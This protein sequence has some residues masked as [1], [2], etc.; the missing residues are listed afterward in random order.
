MRALLQRVSQAS[1][2]IAGTEKSRIDAGILIFLGIERADT[3]DDI[4]W[5]VRKILSLRI[6]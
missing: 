3:E 4:Q 1:V 5:L 6:F 2:T